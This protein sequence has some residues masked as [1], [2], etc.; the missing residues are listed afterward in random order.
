MISQWLLMPMSTWAIAAGLEPGTWS[1]GKLKVQLDQK[2]VQVTLSPK[3]DVSG[4]AIDFTLIDPEGEK[5][6]LRL[7]SMSAE[8]EGR[9]QPPRFQGELR[10]S[11]QSFIGF[12]LT[13]P[14]SSGRKRVIRSEALSRSVPEL[15]Q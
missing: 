15:K 5:T 6:T 13:L 1:D 9:R 8:G 11:A 4:G 3:D 2:K 7:K 14:L 10:S 12:E